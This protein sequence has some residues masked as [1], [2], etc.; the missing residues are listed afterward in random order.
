MVSS[1]SFDDAVSFSIVLLTSGGLSS[2]TCG[3]GRDFSKSGDITACS[4]VIVFLSSGLL[5][6]PSGAWCFDLSSSD[7]TV[8]ISIILSSSGVLGIPSGAVFRFD[9]SKGSRNLVGTVFWSGMNAAVLG[10]LGCCFGMSLV[11]GVKRHTTIPGVACWGFHLSSGDIAASSVV[12]VFLSSGLLWVPGGAWCF[13][14]SSG[15][16]TTCSIVVVFLSSGLL[17][18]PGGA[19]GFNLSKG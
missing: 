1:F 9:L 10:R 8:S 3:A 13:K 11:S 5:W 6:V 17:W 2:S 12:V 14:L 7:N 19:W 18:V 15:D 4:I 16:I